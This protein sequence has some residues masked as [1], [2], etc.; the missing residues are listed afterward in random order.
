MSRD[1]VAGRLDAALGRACDASATP[2]AQAA[3]VRNG[4]VEWRG[5]HGLSDVA[6][7]VPVHDRTVFCLA[8]LGKTLLAALTLGLVERG[9]LELDAPLAVVGGDDIPGSG[10]ITLR[11]LLSHTAGYP[12]LY[13]VPHVQRLMPHDLRAPESGAAYDPDRA[14]T[15]EMLLPGIVEPVS[16]GQRW[17]YSNTGYIVLA[18][19]LCRALGGPSGLQA[20]WTS[21][22]D[23]VDLLGGS[24]PHAPIFD[25]SRVDLSQFAHGYEQQDDGPF[26]DAY[27]AYAPSGVP[28]DLF[29]LPF[30]D[31]LFAGT[32]IGVATF[33]DALFVRRLL[34]APETVE[35]MT[36]TTPEAAAAETTHPDL[37]TYG[38]GTFRMDSSSGAWQ[39]H[40]GMYAGFTTLGGSNPATASTLVL[41]TNSIAE[42]IPAMSIWRELV[43][44]V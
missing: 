15:W 29:G 8:S 30:G 38:L 40:R 42:P 41:L 2:G 20:A 35:L 16:P 32:A 25:R 6:K 17:A 37:N 22:V 39:G 11:L 4:A 43:A 33:L 5:V 36:A 1:D 10:R 44:T 26:V 12:D 28:T 34:L 9:V 21:F 31:G 14:F 18:E 23:G 7:A 27:A 19:A 3:L 13:E 24:G